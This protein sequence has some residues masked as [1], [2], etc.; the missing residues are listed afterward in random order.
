M[1]KDLLEIPEKNLSTYTNFPELLAT[2]LTDLIEPDLC[3]I[4]VSNLR[5]SHTKT[6]VMFQHL[7]SSMDIVHQILI[8]T[9][10]KIKIAD[11]YK[12]M[13]AEVFAFVFRYLEW[14]FYRNKS[15]KQSMHKQIMEIVK[16][17]DIGPVSQCRFLLFMRE[18]TKNN[19]RLVHNLDHVMVC[20][21]KLLDLMA[22]QPGDTSTIRCLVLHI[23]PNLVKCDGEVI[24]ENQNEILRLMFSMK[25]K[26]MFES[27]AG[28]GLLDKLQG[29]LKTRQSFNSFLTIEKTKVMVSHEEVRFVIH[30]LRVLNSCTDQR[31]SFTEHFCQKLYSAEIFQELLSTPKVAFDLKGVA[32]DYL[33]YSFLRSEPRDTLS[34]VYIST[35]MLPILVSEFEAAIKT[36][37][38]QSEDYAEMADVIVVSEHSVEVFDISA[39]QY[40]IKLADLFE[41]L[42]QLDLEEKQYYTLTADLEAGLTQV[43]CIIDRNIGKVLV[44]LQTK[45][46]KVVRTIRKSQTDKS[47]DSLRVKAEEIE[48]KN[49]LAFDLFLKQRE[50]KHSSRKEPELHLQH[51]VMKLLQMMRTD[52]LMACGKDNFEKICRRLEEDESGEGSS[53]HKIG[54]SLLTSLAEEDYFESVDYQVYSF[55][56]GLLQYYLDQAG[57]DENELS[58]RQNDL[59]E[60]DCIR[61]VAAVLCFTENEKLQLDCIKLL[62]GVFENGNKNAQDKLQEMLEEKDGVKSMS[63]LGKIGEQISSKV[64]E[65][66]SVCKKIRNE[67][68]ESQFFKVTAHHSLP[69]RIGDLTTKRRLAETCRFY[70]RLLQ[71]FCEGHNHGIQQMMLTQRRDYENHNFLHS[72]ILI[73]GIFLKYLDTGTEE[74]ISQA[75][76][77]LVES[78]QGPNRDNQECVFHSK[79]FEYLNDYITDFEE[80]IEE[81]KADNE[82]KIQMFSGII[83]K[84][85]AVLSSLLEG[86]TNRK[87]LYLEIEKHISIQSLLQVLTRKF[88]DYFE[89][90]KQNIGDPIYLLHTITTKLFDENLTEMFEIFFFIKYMDRNLADEEAGSILASL[91]SNQENC[92]KFFQHCSGSIEI[93]FQDSVELIYF[94]KQPA[95]EYLS[96][97]NKMQFLDN[98]RRDSTTNKLADL[99]QL[100]KRVNIMMDYNHY[101]SKSGGFIIKASRRVYT[102]IGQVINLFVLIVIIMVFLFDK[103]NSETFLSMKPI[104]AS[105]AAMRYILVVLCLIRILVNSIYLGPLHIKEEWA[106]LFSK[107]AQDQSEMVIADHPDKGRR[108]QRRS[109]T[110]ERQVPGAFRRHRQAGR[111]QESRTDWLC[112]KPSSI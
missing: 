93:I 17:A 35:K 73:Y 67:N 95:A 88:E 100:S 99:Q 40:A 45:L 76:A 106:K 107:F 19:P 42:A 36:I 6:D 66:N 5:Q 43:L 94:V 55:A 75:L 1:I 53:L 32:I 109:R 47:K 16:S 10:F 2:S 25:Y 82:E 23:L 15:A 27:L 110:A 78:I 31:N 57:D 70:F 62:I 18:W 63:I 22:R 29:V 34:I 20:A 112:S 24:K 98:V 33:M 104:D 86:N 83:Q 59:I 65:L 108:R 71:L 87:D 92:R 26:T 77:F 97:E 7:N 21:H 30:F 13:Q 90:H 60:L 105:I 58:G 80:A 111:G 74:M 91:D 46:S 64:Q 11:E 9:N 103:Y 56:I 79:F 84:S 68:M 37:L 81:V 39:E 3:Q 50:V 96:E 44:D 41:E 48:Q 54:A 8:I 85:V 28:R 52:D 38:D 14:F 89:M 51:V 69:E 101:S 72:A 4:V 102:Y 12:I 61:H 49:N